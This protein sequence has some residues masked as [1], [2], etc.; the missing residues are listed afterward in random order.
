M[1]V[2]RLLVNPQSNEPYMVGK[3]DAQDVFRLVAA[4]NTSVHDARNLG[5]IN[6]GAVS[7]YVLLPEPACKRLWKYI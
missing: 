3:Y 1:A 6:W 4:I 2:Y 7:R 5:Q